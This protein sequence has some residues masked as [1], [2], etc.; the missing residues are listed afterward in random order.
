MQDAKKIL[1]KALDE[2][3]V[4]DPHCH[5][6]PH[7]PS[8]DTLADIVLYHHVWIELVSSGMDRFD[9]TEA[10]LPHEVQ[11][12]GMALIER[13]TRCLPYLSN[14]KNTTLGLY[15]RWLLHD[16]YGVEKL[17]KA[18]LEQVCT[19]AEDKGRDSHWPDEILRERCGIEY[20]VT[21]EPGTIPSGGRVLRGVEYCPAC[22]ASGKQTPFEIL[23][24]WETSFGRDIRH[25]DD[26][27][28]FIANVVDAIPLPECR[29]LGW[30][31]LPYVTHESANDDDITDILRRVK[32]RKPLSSADIGS[33]CYFGMTAILDRLR[34]TTLRTIQ[35]IV[36]AEA[37]PPHRSIT[38]WHSSFAGAVGR[39]AGRYEEFHFNLSSASDIYTQDLAILAKHI[40]N[41]SVAGYWWHTLYPFYIRKS[42][43]TRL[44]MVPLNKIIGF[45]SDAYHAEWCYPKLKMVKEILLEILLERIAKGWYDVDMALEIVNK[46][47]Y[48]TP[49]RIYN[50]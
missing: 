36:G 14:I 49:K 6:R 18:N 12:P 44:D 28:A 23:T 38:H 41:I 50:V 1:S 24:G 5:L 9:V 48:E 33:F 34:T 42:L 35:L 20:N 7:K 10:G 27:L 40:P 22:L 2:V 26:Y 30:W 16:L 13:M 15:L 11:D 4:I 32:D 31:I 39:L 29:F 3:N 46:L 43:E 37:L 25:A 19:L 21:V 45:F 47:F 17:T 8:A